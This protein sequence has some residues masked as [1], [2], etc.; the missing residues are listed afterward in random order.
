L[1][2]SRSFNSPEWLKTMILFI[3]SCFSVVTAFLS[4]I[5]PNR[6]IVSFPKLNSRRSLIKFSNSVPSALTLV[7]TTGK[8]HGIIT[9]TIHDF[10]NWSMSHDCIPKCTLKLVTCI[11]EQH[12]SVVGFDLINNGFYLCCTTPACILFYFFN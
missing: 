7:D 5:T 12:I 9:Q 10:G 3:P 1:H 8:S 4:V 11:K 6:A 2:I